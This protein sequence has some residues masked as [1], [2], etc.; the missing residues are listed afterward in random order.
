VSL[1]R[2]AC[3]CLTTVT[4]TRA[5][6]AGIRASSYRA[7]IKRLPPEAHLFSS[8]SQFTTNVNGTLAVEVFAD[9]KKRCPSDVTSYKFPRGWPL[10]IENSAC[11]APGVIFLPFFL[12][13][14]CHHV[15]VLRRK[16]KQLFAIAAPMRVS[17]ALGG[18]R[19][20]PRRI[21]KVRQIYFPLSRFVRAVSHPFAIGR[22]CRIRIGELRLHQRERL[23]VSH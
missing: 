7:T 9:S 23:P 18:H 20:S 13:A 21:R 12:H 5:S 8:A 6:L 16:I 17:S 15:L 4:A 1:I 10:G 2:F 22:E 3:T 11:G 19:K 14:Y